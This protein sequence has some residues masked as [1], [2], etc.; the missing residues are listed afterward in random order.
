MQGNLNWMQGYEALRKFFCPPPPECQVIALDW[1]FSTMFKPLFEPLVTLGIERKLL[2][3]APEHGSSLC[4][5]FR[6]FSRRSCFAQ[7]LPASRGRVN[8]PNAWFSAPAVG[9]KLIFSKILTYVRAYFG[10][11]ITS[12]RL[13]P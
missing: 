8:S 3:G 11:K 7:T 13:F 6:G 2:R 1:V 12:F 5:W 4:N 9:S 10:V